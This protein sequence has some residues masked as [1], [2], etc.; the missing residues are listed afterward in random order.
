MFLETFLVRGTN[1]QK[2]GTTKN[3]PQNYRFRSSA[4]NL[5]VLR[6]AQKEFRTLMQDKFNEYFE[7]T[8]DMLNDTRSKDFWNHINKLMEEKTD[9]EV[10]PLFKNDKFYFQTKGKAG[11]LREKDKHLQGIAFNE[12]NKIL[13]EKRLPGLLQARTVDTRETWY[14]SDFT[15]EELTLR[16]LNIRESLRQRRY[17]P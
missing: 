17:T 2:P 12:D 10:A 4:H 9:S 1:N 13:V 5:K 6:D 14:N 11:I 3:C 7:N 16:N 8:I 15:L